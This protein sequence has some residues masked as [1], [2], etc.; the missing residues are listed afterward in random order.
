MSFCQTKI[1]M[2]A[3]PLI[4]FR[5]AKLINRFFPGQGSRIAHKLARFI[6]TRLNA[7]ARRKGVVRGTIVIWQRPGH[8]TSESFDWVKPYGTQV[9]V[10]NEMTMISP[11]TE[12]AIF[13]GLPNTHTKYPAYPGYSGSGVI[14]AIGSKKLRFRIGD[15]VAGPFSHASLILVNE[16]KIFNIPNVVSYEAAAFIKLAIIALQ[17]IRKVQPLLGRSVAIL[18][19]GVIGQLAI[20]F[21]SL[22]GAHP[23]IAIAHSSQKLE[24]SQKSGCTEF[25]ALDEKLHML[26]HLNVDIAIEASGHPEAVL[27]ALRCVHPA[28]QV[29]L[30]GSSRGHTTG[31]DIGKWIVERGVKIF[32]AHT[33]VLPQID[34]LPNWWTANREGDVFMALLARRDLRLEHLITERVHPDEAEWFY[35]RL[36]RGEKR[37]VCAIFDWSQLDDARRMRSRCFFSGPKNLLIMERLFL[38]SPDPRPGYCWP[39]LS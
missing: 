19:Q 18:G 35:K 2:R 5:M 4:M 23:I 9:L 39:P 27:Y 7:I 31:I 17:G 10:R 26:D 24:I 25:F 16:E 37:I 20:Q 11:G 36:A 14:K 13:C 15:R 6:I 28:G 33:D 29:V 34:S 30:L 21:A 8:A 12:R 1:K 22:S 32:G 38:E 3:K